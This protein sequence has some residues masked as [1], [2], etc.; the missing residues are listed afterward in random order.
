MAQQQ[1]NTKKF[2]VKSPFPIPSYPLHLLSSAY[3]DKVCICKLNPSLYNV[4]H[5]AMSLLQSGYFLFTSYNL[6]F[7]CA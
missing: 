4:I 2:T 1:D 5:R 6:L 7:Y 3:G